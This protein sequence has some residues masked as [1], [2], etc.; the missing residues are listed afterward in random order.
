MAREFAATGSAKVTQKAD[1]DSAVVENRAVSKSATAAAGRA[2]GRGCRRN[3][4]R[5]GK[6]EGDDTV[7]KN[8]VGEEGEKDGE[9]G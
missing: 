5:H 7:K 4:G 1:K 2:D 8:I 9:I 3:G 6:K